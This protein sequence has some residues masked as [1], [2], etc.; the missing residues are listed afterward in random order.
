[1]KKKTVRFVRRFSSFLKMRPGGFALL[2]VLM[3]VSALSVLVMTHTRESL[4]N[5]R[6]MRNFSDAKR[7]HYWAYGAY[8]LAI[9]I[10]QKD[11]NNYDGPGDI[12]YG[13]LPPIPVENAI[14]SISIEDE[15]SR[16]NISYLVNQFGI[17]DKRRRAMLTRIFDQLGLDEDLIAGMVDWQDKDEIPVSGGAESS[18]YMSLL[19]PYQVPNE[20]FKSPGEVLLVKG[21]GRKEYFLPPSAREVHTEEGF[22]ALRDYITVYGDGRININT[23][24]IIVLMCLSED[25]SKSIAEDIVSYREENAFKSIEELKNVESVTDVLYDEIKDLIT[26]K[27]NVFRVTCTGIINGITETIEAVLFR[28]SRGVRVVY[29]ARSA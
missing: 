10:L 6:M 16:F 17:E 20:R 14:V 23:A 15:K 1:M 19:P 28:Q 8:N 9:S 4:I 5:L 27:S 13:E 12:W 2:S 24:P 21:M 3:I 26:V 25:M 18:Y 7:A 29:F 22:S 11:N